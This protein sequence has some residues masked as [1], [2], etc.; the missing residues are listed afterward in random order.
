MLRNTKLWKIK[1]ILLAIVPLSFSV[2]Y[3]GLQHVE[4]FTPRTFELSALDRAIAFSPQWVYV[5]QSLY[6]L[7]PIVP[8]LLTRRDQLERYMKGLVWISA[9]SFL[10]F[11]FFPV[12]APRPDG[13]TG[14]AAYDLLT[15]YEGKVNA[16]P[17]LHAA[18][19]AYSLLFAR[20]AFRGRA[21]TFV[22][23]L[24]GGA[25]LYATLAT[26]QHYAIDLPAGIVLAWICHRRLAD[27]LPRPLHM[28]T[29]G[30]GAADGHSKG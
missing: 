18:F 8:L 1:L 23:T 2:V 21:L 9:L 16:F 14:V 29:L 11:L 6:V 12:L 25:I 10:I 17:S 4:F 20:W 7:M 27:Q 5:Y 19:V 26:K 22:G 28:R 15:R 24:W 30:V 13:L 3:L